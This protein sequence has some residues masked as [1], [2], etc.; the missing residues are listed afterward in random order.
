GTDPK[1][2]EAQ[3]PDI[4]H[5]HNQQL[6]EDNLDWQYKLQ[7]I[8]S[9]HLHSDRQHEMSV[10]GRAAYVYALLVVAILILVI[11]YINYINLV[12]VKAMQRAKEI[13]IRKVSGALRVQLIGQFVVESLCVNL[14]ALA[15]AIV[16]SD[17]VRPQTAKIFDVTFL[18]LRAM[19][20]QPVL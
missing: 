13:G 1:A 16:L 9:I 15:L 2:L 10:N 19:F 12:T 6:A 18:S 7:P 20:L 5:R 17:A 3:F 8:K 4:V 11:A 14:I